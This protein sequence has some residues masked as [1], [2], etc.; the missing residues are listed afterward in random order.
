MGNREDP[1]SGSAMHPDNI[2]TWLTDWERT[3]HMLC[4]VDKCLS[5]FMT[6]RMCLHELLSFWIFYCLDLNHFVCV[7]YLFIFS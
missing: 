2:L 3:V 6:L 4:I 1:H 7:F 5:V